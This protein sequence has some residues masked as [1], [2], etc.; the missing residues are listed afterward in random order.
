MVHTSA[1]TDEAHVADSSQWVPH[2]SAFG[3]VRTAARTVFGLGQRCPARELHLA[4]E[5][6]VHSMVPTALPPGAFLAV[7]QGWMG[8]D[9]RFE[10]VVS[11]EDRDSL[12]T[13]LSVDS[14]DR[15]RSGCFVELDC[16]A[17][18][19]NVLK[20]LYAELCWLVKKLATCLLFCVSKI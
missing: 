9:E 3:D 18:G 5:H 11:E 15:W 7:V 20:N 10:G 1:Q 17:L 19:Q 14:H 4:P 16:L 8:S 6:G 13:D 12:R 2:N